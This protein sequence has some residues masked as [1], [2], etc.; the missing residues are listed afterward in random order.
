MAMNVVMFLSS[1]R[2]TQETRTF[3]ICKNL[4]FAVN[5]QFTPQQR[6]RS[7]ALE[8]VVLHPYWHAELG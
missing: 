3:Q 1:V 6:N 4:R 2:K 8:S 7:S 5:G